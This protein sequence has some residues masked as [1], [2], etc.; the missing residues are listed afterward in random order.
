MTTAPIRIASAEDFHPVL[1]RLC[2]HCASSQFTPNI[3]LAA[4]LGIGKPHRLL[5]AIYDHVA[6]HKT[7]E[8]IIY[9]A[10]SLNPPRGKSELEKRFLTPFV[11]RIYGADFPR[12]KYADDQ[13]KGALPSN[14]S[15][16]EFYLQSG[17]YLN[18]ALA[19]ASYNSLN[20]THVAGALADSE[21]N[22]LVQKVASDGQGNYS[23]S[24]NTDLTVDVLRALEHA[25]KPRPLCIA[26]IDPELPWV[27]GSAVVDDEFFDIVI[28]HTQ[29]AGHLFALPRQP[30]GDVEYA[31]GFYASTLIKDG[32]TLQI[33]IGALSDALCY[34]LILR[35]TQNQTYRNI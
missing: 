31:I 6:A 16:Q 29:P 19:Q 25:G 1:Q 26:E 34:A 12:L 32:G 24:S 14:I 27:G 3:R 35:H 18:N 33:G 22:V 7:Q 2:E 30:V 23:L 8:M 9:T 15:V 13:Q 28:E 21:V 5:N 11:E 20:Y 10:L 17:A 4:P